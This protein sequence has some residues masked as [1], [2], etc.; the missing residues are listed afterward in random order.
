M[1][2]LKLSIQNKLSVKIL[3]LLGFVPEIQIWFNICKSAS[4]THLSNKWF[5]RN[6]MIIPTG[7]EKSLIKSSTPS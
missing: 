6:H 3:D 4:V 1:Q 5:K 7:A 2:K